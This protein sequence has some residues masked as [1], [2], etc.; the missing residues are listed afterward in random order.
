[1]IVVLAALGIM[2][3]CAL[4][5]WQVFRRLGRT[6]ERIDRLTLHRETTPRVQ[7]IERTT[8]QAEATRGRAEA[9][10]RQLEAISRGRRAP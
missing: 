2:V 10:Q 9:L 8:Q 7:E 1:V 4:L 6:A 5:T 3:G